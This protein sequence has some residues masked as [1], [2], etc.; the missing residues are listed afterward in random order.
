M[1]HLLI[2]FIG[3][4]GDILHR[5]EFFNNND[6]NKMFEIIQM[7]PR[8]QY[9]ITDIINRYGITI[10]VLS[11]LIKKLMKHKIFYTNKQRVILFN[12]KLIYVSNLGLYT[13]IDKLRI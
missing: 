8:K 10:Q 9:V 4:N 11:I 13:N 5:Y 1:E 3:R 12:N 7:S 6:I 2:T